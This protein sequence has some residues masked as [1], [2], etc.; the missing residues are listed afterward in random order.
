VEV[1][2][3]D[4]AAQEKET[5][6]RVFVLALLPMYRNHDTS[7]RELIWKNQEQ[8]RRLLVRSSISRYF[9]E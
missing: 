5:I 7:P 6:T 9:N 2:P 4:I 8:K 1:E 3:G